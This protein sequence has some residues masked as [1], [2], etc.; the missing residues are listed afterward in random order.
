LSLVRAFNKNGT[1]DPMDYER[2]DDI[3]FWIMEEDT[4][5]TPILDTNEIESVLYNEELILI[6]GLDNKEGENGILLMCIELYYDK[7]MKM[8]DLIVYFIFR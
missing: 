8:Q 4:N 2:I 6:V 1:Y 5:S 7:F 3:E